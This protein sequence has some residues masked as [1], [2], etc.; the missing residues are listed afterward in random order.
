MFESISN[1][2]TDLD[3]AL[4]GNLEDIVIGI[5]IIIVVIVVIVLIVKYVKYQKSLYKPPPTTTQP[6]TTQPPTFIKSLETNTRLQYIVIGS[7][8]AVFILI[9]VIVY[10]ATASK[11]AGNHK[12][13]RPEHARRSYSYYK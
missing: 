3:V 1:S 2:L 9:A 8:I 6:Q 7:I 5:C 10:F 4:G 12:I 13:R 11:R